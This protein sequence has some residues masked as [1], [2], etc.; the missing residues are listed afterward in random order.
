MACERPGTSALR[1]EDLD[2]GALHDQLAHEVHELVQALG[3]DAHGGGGA[4]AVGAVGGDDGDGHRL[5]RLGAG[6][7]AG[8]GDL[9]DLGGRRRPAR[10]SGRR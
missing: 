7:D 6:D 4:R 9:G 3:V 10:R 1:G 5:D 2:L 8:L